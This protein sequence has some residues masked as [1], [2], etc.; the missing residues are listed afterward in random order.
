MSKCLRTYNDMRCSPLLVWGTSS[1]CLSSTL[2]TPCM[3][4]SLLSRLQRQACCEYMHTL[5]T[6]TRTYSLYSQS[7]QCTQSVVDKTPA[8]L[9]EQWEGG[10]AGEQIYRLLQFIV[11]TFTLDYVLLTGGN[12]LT[13]F[14]RFG[15]G[16]TNNYRGP[17]IELLGRGVRLFIQYCARCMRILSTMRSRNQMLF[18]RTSK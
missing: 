11:G 3:H 1:W 8:N 6:C 5:H 9:T 18:F 10:G 17:P 16:F 14:M 7:I 12:S 13:R 2:D 15:S 4:A